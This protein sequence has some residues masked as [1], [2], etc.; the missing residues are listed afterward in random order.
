M[1]R[2]NSLQACNKKLVTRSQDAE[3]SWRHPYSSPAIRLRLELSLILKNSLIIHGTS[4]DKTT[5]KEMIKIDRN[6][7]LILLSVVAVAAILGSTVLAASASD[8]GEKSSCPYNRRLYDLT[9]EQ[10]EAIRQKVQEM[11][12][13]GASREEIQATIT[14]ML[15]EWGIEA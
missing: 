11:R 9:D 1:V 2:N 12:A 4:I 7:A 5:K 10:R 13:A 14:E 3:G 15:Q 8:N 6:K